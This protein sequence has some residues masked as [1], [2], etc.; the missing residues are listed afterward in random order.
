MCLCEASARKDPR[1]GPGTIWE[2]KEVDS[3][4]QSFIVTDALR[5][6]FHMVLIASCTGSRIALTLQGRKLDP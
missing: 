2:G 6:Q 4:I 1:S 3:C 5:I